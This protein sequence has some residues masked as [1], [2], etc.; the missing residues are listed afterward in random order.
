MMLRWLWDEPYFPGGGGDITDK[1]S[2]SGPGSRP[3][4]TCWQPRETT[5]RLRPPS[6]SSIT[7]TLY[8]FRL[9]RFKN[10][11]VKLTGESCAVAFFSVRSR[12]HTNTHGPHTHT[13]THFCVCVVHP[14]SADGG[15]ADAFEA[16]W[17]EPAPAPRATNSHWRPPGSLGTC[18]FQVHSWSTHTHTHTQAGV[19]SS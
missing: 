18:C 8:L 4:R 10:T 7:S 1:R 9:F 19:T 16:C 15:C 17:E 2:T 11:F 5:A 3:S 14:H 13:H 6:I 12:T